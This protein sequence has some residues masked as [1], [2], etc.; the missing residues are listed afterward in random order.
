[1]KC[2]HCGIKIDNPMIFHIHENRCLEDQRANGFIKDNKENDI[3]YNSMTVEQLKVICKDKGLE[4]YSNFN[5]DE[6]I[7]FM[8]E[9]IQL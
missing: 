2:K 1:M 3:D 6:L 8:K 5:K 4:G 7:A 9:K